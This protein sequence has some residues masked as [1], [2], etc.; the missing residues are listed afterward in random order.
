MGKIFARLSPQNDQQANIEFY[1]AHHQSFQY[2]SQV[3]A[4][5]ELIH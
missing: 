4:L 3:D 1:L 2:P 5:M